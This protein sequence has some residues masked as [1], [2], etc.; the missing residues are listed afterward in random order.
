[1]KTVSSYTHTVSIFLG[2]KKGQQELQRYEYVRHFVNLYRFQCFWFMVYDAISCMQKFTL[3]YKITDTY[4]I[5]SDE[6][7]TVSQKLSV[8]SKTQTIVNT[9]IC[10]GMFTSHNSYLLPNK[11]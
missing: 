3:K 6:Q 9:C 2:V 11:G 1:M 7:I 8:A 4:L 10:A 5:I